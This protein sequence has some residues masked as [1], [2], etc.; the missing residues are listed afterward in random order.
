[1][2]KALVKIIWI[3][4]ILI[5]LMQNSIIYALTEKEELQQEI[6]NAGQILMEI[7]ES[8]A[9]IGAGLKAD[10]GELLIRWEMW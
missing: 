7:S 2:K 6:V 10:I 5:L 1:M 4:I 3:F 8:G 9:S